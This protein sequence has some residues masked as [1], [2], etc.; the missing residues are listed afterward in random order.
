M[1]LQLLVPKILFL[2]KLIVKMVL[3]NFITTQGSLLSNSLFHKPLYFLKSDPMNHKLWKN[4]KN[5][6]SL[7]RV[8]KLETFKI[9]FLKN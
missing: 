3:R 5:N 1:L 8:K 2:G 4:L 7:T 6:P 9:R